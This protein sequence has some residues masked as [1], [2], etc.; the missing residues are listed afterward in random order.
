M[1]F[2]NEQKELRKN[3]RTNERTA[4][5]AKKKTE[6][7]RK[8]F[9]YH[10][11]FFNFF[12]YISFLNTIIYLTISPSA[13]V[14][15]SYARLGKKNRRINQPT[16]QPT[17]SQ[18]NNECA[19]GR[20]KK[21]N[22][23]NKQTTIKKAGSNLYGVFTKNHPPLFP[24]ALNKQ[25]SF[26]LFFLLIRCSFISICLLFSS[27]IFFIFS[28]S[29]VNFFYHESRLCCF[30]RITPNGSVN[31]NCVLVLRWTPLKK[32]NFKW[33]ILLRFFPSFSLATLFPF[34]F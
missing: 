18:V 31:S 3:E 1:K 30:D 22:S 32:W 33:N 20:E 9:R 16:N 6:L 24:R 26:L 17:I 19:R 11:F 13:S 28:S 15:K 12:H 7:K 34:R 29:L 27:I 10:R 25:L 4:K 8:A 2:G 23:N 14:H 5:R 21:I